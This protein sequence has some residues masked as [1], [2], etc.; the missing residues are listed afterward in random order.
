VQYNEEILSRLTNRGVRVVP[1][2]TTGHN[3]W[4]PNFGVESMG[5]LFYNRSIS[6]PAG[7]LGSR[8]RLRVLEDQLS[9]FPMGR[10]SD[11]VMALWFA[12]LGARDLFQRGRAPLFHPRMKVPARISRQR[13]VFDFSDRTVSAPRSDM[14]MYGR[15]A[16]AGFEEPAKVKLVNVSGEVSVY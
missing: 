16:F 2:I 12:E 6:T 11:L 9:T 8:N 14:E 13:R 7:D 10:S 5:P 3:K 15:P 1:H 4:D